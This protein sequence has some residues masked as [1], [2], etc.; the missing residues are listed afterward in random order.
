MLKSKP[1]PPN[2]A[3]ISPILRSGSQDQGAKTKN[4]I[5]ELLNDQAARVKEAAKQYAETG[6]QQAKNI[7]NQENLH[8]HGQIHV[9]WQE[10]GNKANPDLLTVEQ[11]TMS[12]LQDQ[13]NLAVENA[14][15]VKT[16]R[17]HYVNLGD[18]K[19]KDGKTVGAHI[20]EKL[21]HPDHDT[22]EKLLNAVEKEVLDAMRDKGYDEKLFIQ[23][24]FMEARFHKGQ[25]GA[26]EPAASQVWE[27]D[28][29]KASRILD[30]K[31]ILD[32]YNAL[33]KEGLLSERAIN[34]VEQLYKGLDTARSEQER[35]DIWRNILITTV[36]DQRNS[37]TQAH[38]DLSEFMEKAEKHEGDMAA[39]KKNLEEQSKLAEHMLDEAIKQEKKAGTLKS[40]LKTSKEVQYN[41]DWKIELIQ[42][43]RLAQD[44]MLD[45]LKK[46]KADAAAMAKF[47]KQMAELKKELNSVGRSTPIK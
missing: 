10:M 4:D 34:T 43:I 5:F 46:G 28:A 14:A 17:I 18:I 21:T 31:L 32:Y 12:T 22:K 16:E 33:E 15:K 40:K 27:Q 36:T 38:K 11:Q 7:L 24:L 39:L 2:V 8:L 47:E 44:E 45:T 13:A 30:E 29:Q 42:R 20:Y 41:Q 37:L 26:P 9:F 25:Q 6:T 19:A 3:T 35:A 1:S 23:R